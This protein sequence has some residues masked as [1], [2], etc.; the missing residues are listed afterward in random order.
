MGARGRKHIVIDGNSR[1]GK[2]WALGDGKFVGSRLTARGKFEER[3]FS[4]TERNVKDE[5]RAWASETREEALIQVPPPTHK[6]QPQEKGVDVATT[7]TAPKRATSAP[8]KI[9]VLRYVVGKVSRN[10]AAFTSQ[11]AAL[12]AAELLNDFGGAVNDSGDFEFDELD[13]RG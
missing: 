6:E 12:S 2:L 13:V 8:K 3:Q 9:Y 4:G 1:T 7:T 5:W 11:D 10:V